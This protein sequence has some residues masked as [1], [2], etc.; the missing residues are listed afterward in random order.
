MDNTAILEHNMM[1]RQ[2]I[3]TQIA[4]LQQ[5]LSAPTSNIGDWKIIKIYEA[6]LQGAPDPYNY[7]E[8]AQARQA[9]R[10]QINQLQSQLNQG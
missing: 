5:H 6:R 1:E 7:N 8:L 3:E 4:C 9:I 10:N 2:R